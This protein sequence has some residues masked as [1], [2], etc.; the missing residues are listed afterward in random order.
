MRLPGIR[1][2]PLRM[3]MYLDDLQTISAT[4]NLLLHELPLFQGLLFHPPP[5][6][7]VQ[8]QGSYHRPLDLHPLATFCPR[9]RGV[10]DRR[11]S[12]KC[13]LVHCNP[14]RLRH[15]LR[16]SWPPTQ[17]HLAYSAHLPA[18]A[19]ALARFVAPLTLHIAPLKDI[20]L[21]NSATLQ[22]F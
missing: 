9:V 22:N 1:P 12:H 19:T 17:S 13:K 21:T 15:Y 16:L 2:F 5:N 7:G 8:L 10:E 6:S 3:L 18:E 11:I 4:P 14:H 20:E